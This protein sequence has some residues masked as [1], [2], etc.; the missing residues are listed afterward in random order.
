MALYMT[1]D[2]EYELQK[3]FADWGRDYY[4]P[5]GYGAILDYY[6][7]VDSELDVI[8]ICGD[9]TE[10]EDFTVM[11][12]DY[13]IDD[14]YQFMYDNDYTTD[15]EE[16]NGFDSDDELTDDD[17][18]RMMNELNTEDFISEYKGFVFDEMDNS[19]YDVIELDNGN[20]LVMG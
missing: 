14:F 16:E 20:Y 18:T 4:S 10:Y 3:I 13:G 11:A 17:R 12:K 8:A 19:Y 5:D 15:W 6:N 1:I 2:N 7:E 9:F